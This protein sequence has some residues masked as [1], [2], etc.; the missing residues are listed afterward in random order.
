MVDLPVSDEPNV[1]KT[2]IRKR[3]G[4]SKPGVAAD[5]YR[6]RLLRVREAPGGTSLQSP[7]P[8]ARNALQALT[9][10]HGSA[11]ECK[12]GAAGGPNF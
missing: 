7:R 6:S 5:I 12:P 10:L 8:R 9:V 11:R 1:K 2:S 4:Y 3:R